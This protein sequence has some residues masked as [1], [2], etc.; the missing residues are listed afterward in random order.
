MVRKRYTEGQII[1]VLNEAEAGAKTVDLC[2]KHGVSDAT[3]YNWK[4]KYAGL[5]VSELKRLGS[6][7]DENRRLKQ[8]VA[9]QALDNWALMA[10]LSVPY[11]GGSAVS[12]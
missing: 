11:D 6:P 3:F 5:T 10:G 4:A 7:E 1:A 8:I 12:R 2:R 9:Q